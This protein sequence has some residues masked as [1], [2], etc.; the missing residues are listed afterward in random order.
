MKTE[1]INQVKENILK[2]FN[3]LVAYSN[4]EKTAFLSGADQFRHAMYMQDMIS[5]DENDALSLM[6]MQLNTH[7]PWKRKESQNVAMLN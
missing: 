6:M 7:K 5:A 4:D 2:A 1:Q 3:I